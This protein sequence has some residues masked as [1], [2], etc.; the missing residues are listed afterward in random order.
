MP[1]TGSR[2]AG[3]N[4][5]LSAFPGC[6]VARHSGRKVP[7]RCIQPG[8]SSQGPGEELTDGGAALCL[9][10]GPDR[11]RNTPSAQRGRGNCQER[12]DPMQ[13]IATQFSCHDTA[14]RCTTQAPSTV[15]SWTCA[16]RRWGSFVRGASRGGVNEKQLPVLAERHVR[17]PRWRKGIVLL[18]SCCLPPCLPGRQFV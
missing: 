10:V 1:C 3:S 5:A 17:S 12:P 9:L 4:P 2:T 14:D 16:S 8:G 6:L 7:C 11:S 18:P 15:L 13:G